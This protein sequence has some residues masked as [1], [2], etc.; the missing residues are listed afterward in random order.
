MCR[1]DLTRCCKLLTFFSFICN[2]WEA[3][4][5]QRIVI[6]S[7]HI[8]SSIEWD[9][10]LPLNFH[11]HK[12]TIIALPILKCLNS[13]CLPFHLQAHGHRKTITSDQHSYKYGHSLTFTFILPHYIVI[14]YYT[15]SSLKYFYNLT[16]WFLMRLVGQQFWYK[17]TKNPVIHGRYCGTD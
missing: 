3:L 17:P 14:Y 1:V 11:N 8:P 5:T 15:V 4:S 9:Q 16:V 7:R 6:C 2:I 13:G 12:E 10:T